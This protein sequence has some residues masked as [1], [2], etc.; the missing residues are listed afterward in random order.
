MAR[1]LG[2]ASRRS[3]TL[4]S[5]CACACAC[6]LVCV[7]VAGLARSLV[8]GVM[9]DGMTADGRKAREVKRLATDSNEAV[10]YFDPNISS[11]ERRKL[12]QALKM[13]GMAPPGAGQSPR[14]GDSDSLDGETPPAASAAAKADSTPPTLKRRGSSTSDGA[15]KRRTGVSKGAGV[16]RGSG[17]SA[18]G[19]AS[20]STAPQDSAAATASRTQDS[21]ARDHVIDVG[22][23]LGKLNPGELGS[24]AARPQASGRK[25]AAAAAGHKRSAA[26]SK[27]AAVRCPLST[28]STTLQL[29]HRLDF[30]CFSH[31]QL[32]K[33]HHPVLAYAIHT[34]DSTGPD[35]HS[36]P[37]RADNGPEA[38]PW[39]NAVPHPL[40]GTRPFLRH[41]GARRK[42]PH[43]GPLEKAL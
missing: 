18:A 32:L 28:S 13:M 40:D 25:G 34:V 39:A 15:K 12:M 30:A 20:A 16:R 1:G 8:A 41:M 3:K 31:A 10:E 27:P 38:A 19:S 37:G 14:Q 33:F 11:R 35:R 42:H 29:L 17:S 7:C 5:L 43:S 6:V 2:E 24:A 23:P 21:E 22:V 36:A 9:A 4:P 26:T